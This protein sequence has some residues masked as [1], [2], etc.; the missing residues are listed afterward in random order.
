VPLG[1]D[2]IDELR[3]AAAARYLAGRITANRME[4]ISRSRAIALRF[5]PSTP[6]YQFAAFV[7]G[8]GNGVRSA[9]ITGGV[10]PP[11]G[12]PRR[13]SDD[14]PNVHFGLE[15]GSPD[16]DGVRNASADGVRVGASRILTVSPDG[17]SSSG[18]LYVQGRRAQYAVRVLGATGRTRVLKYDTGARTWISR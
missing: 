18:T 13:L 9:E 8:N 6:D 3:T 16:V 10:D 1:G 12:T 2:A 7:D 11:V 4:A 15:I 5:Q 17:T 14:F